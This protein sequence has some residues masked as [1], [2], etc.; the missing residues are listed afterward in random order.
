MTQLHLHIITN[1]S[2]TIFSLDYNVNIFRGGGD[3]LWY[4]LHWEYFE[5]ISLPNN[6]IFN[7]FSLK[8][9]ANNILDKALKGKKKNNVWHVEN[10]Y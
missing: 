3:I 2:Y 10:C 5:L 1:I 9:F 7:S 8:I 6:N 4:I